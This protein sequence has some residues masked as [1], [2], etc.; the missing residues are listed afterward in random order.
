MPDWKKEIRERLAGLR[1]APTRETEIVEELAQYLEDC[2]EELLA[3][4]ATKEDAWRRTME[5]LNESDLLA[6]ELNKIERPVNEEPVV[7]GARGART[8]NV[9]RDLLRDLS[10]GIRILLKSKGFTIVTVLS[11]ALGIGANTALFSVVDAV[12]LKTLPVKEPERLVLFEWQAGRQFRTNGMSGTSN[13]PAPPGTKALS[14]FRYEV[15]EK[16]RQARVAP[17][18]PLSDFFAFAPIRE[19]TAVVDQ[20][21]EII[22]GQAVSG[23]Y[24]AGLGVQASLGRIITDQDDKPGAAPVVVLS[25]QFWQER[26]GANPAVIGQPLKLN[27]QSFT[28]IGVTAAA[29]TG[30]LQVDYHPAVTIPLAFEPLLQGENSKLGSSDTPGVWW[31]NLMG[32]LKPGATYEQARDS[33]NGTFQAAALEVRPPPRKAS[34]PAQLDP[35][36]YPRLIVESGSRGMLD[37]RRSYSSTI[38]GLFLVVALVL[39]IACANVANL[40]LARAALRGAE[41]SVRLAVG[42][43]RWRLV[44]QL[45]TESVLLAALGGAVGVIFA[46]WGKRALMALAYKNTGILPNEVDLSLNWRVLV[47]TLAVS[48]LT[49]VVFG[50]APAWRATGLDLATSLKQ[51]RRT[52]GAVSRLSKGLIVTQVALSLLL[53]VGAGLFIRTLYNLQRVNLG[54]NQENLLVFTLQPEQ[55]GYKDE[56][57]LQFYQQLF[58]RL[59]HQPG[60]RAATFGKVALIADDNWFNDFLLPGE[61]EKTAVEHDTMRQMVRE[62]YFATME[63]PLLRGRGFTAQDDQRAPKVAIVSQTFAQKFFP[64]DDVLGQRVTIIDDTHEV[65]IVGVVADTKYMS[66][67]E[68]LQPLL[69]TPWQQEGGVIGGMHFAVRTTGEPGTLA[70]TI[71]QVV[72]ELDSNL[73]VTDI[74]TQ[75]ELAQATLGGERLYARL[76]SF[77]GG[78]ALLLAAIGLSGVLAYSVAQRTNEMGIRMALGAQ[79]ANVLRLVVWQGMR[80]VLLGLAVGAVAGYGLKRLLASQYFGED[81]WQRQ[82]AEQLYGVN[83]TDPLTF[84]VIAGLLTLVA[85]VACWLPARKAA[86]VDPLEALRYE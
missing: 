13:V 75:S 25:H 1:L 67:R 77:F 5:G 70:V 58:D 62:N 35:K 65:E 86:Q 20:Q 10:F 51:S 52:T 56:R 39:L 53:L 68:E 44:R 2:Y 54:F 63:I 71:R 19:L 43:G 84:L 42:A 64:N 34:E 24:Y 79:T 15:F 60:V 69:Y 31:L 36:D 49:G 76:L 21:A 16:M 30:T 27:K 81:A 45:L 59:D 23:G 8:T 41:I 61:A 18:S 11:L 78:L 32:R 72:H 38:Y 48:L 57:L 3:S 14:L 9:L 47:F 37:I 83:G 55:S 82:M 28:I 46:W 17:H 73:P 12:L 33:L 4:G 40:L 50:L 6:Q 29:F 66:Q 74:T 80:L 26:F 85:L 22:K 7:L